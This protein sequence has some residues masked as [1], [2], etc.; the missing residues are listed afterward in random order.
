MSRSLVV[1][2]NVVVTRLSR[3]EGLL[4]TSIG[5]LRMT[6]ISRFMVNYMGRLMM[7]YIGRLMM[8]NMDRLV[9]SRGST[10]L[11]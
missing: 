5:C 3:V 10:S 9:D 2:N 1:T 4:E 11:I 8:R 6:G 7:S